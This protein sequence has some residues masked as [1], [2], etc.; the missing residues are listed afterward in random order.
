MLPNEEKILQ[1]IKTPYNKYPI[2]MIWATSVLHRA[3]K[4]NLIKNDVAVAQIN[5]VRPTVT[6]R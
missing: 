2:P 4:E 6:L 1:E 3:R 5:E